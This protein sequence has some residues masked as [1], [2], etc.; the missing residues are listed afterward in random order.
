MG[1]GGGFTT[2]SP[3]CCALSQAKEA[4][5]DL[6]CTL[7]S[8]PAHQLFSVPIPAAGRSQSPE[9]GAGRPAGRDPAAAAIP[10][11][12]RPSHKLL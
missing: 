10:L 4:A 5:G 1:G 8:S 2:S 12:V 3:C 11:G 6:H 7:P 9:A